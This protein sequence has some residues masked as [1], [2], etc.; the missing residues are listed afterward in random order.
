MRSFLLRSLF[1]CVLLYKK[2]WLRKD[3]RYFKPQCCFPPGLTE[4]FIY[5]F[6]QS[7]DEDKVLLSRGSL[8]AFYPIFN[9]FLS[10]PFLL[11]KFGDF[12]LFL[13]A[14][15]QSKKIFGWRLFVAIVAY[16]I[17]DCLKRSLI[18]SSNV[19]FY[20]AILCFNR[21]TSKML[22]FILKLMFHRFEDR[23]YKMTSSWINNMSFKNFLFQ[24]CSTLQT[25]VRSFVSSIN[26]T[27]P[28][29]Q[30]A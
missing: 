19:M 25:F 1:S 5:N 4:P 20:L 27:S 29:I 12:P 16:R 7:R 17:T 30:S 9:N 2:H 10:I 14:S 21:V 15:G 13:V 11:F 26:P 22:F 6:P 28:L 24:F 23:R 8:L 3:K 18:N